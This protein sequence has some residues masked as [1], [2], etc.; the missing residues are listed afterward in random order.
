MQMLSTPPTLP[1]QTIPLGILT[2]IR[3]EDMTLFDKPPVP[4]PGTSS[5]TSACWKA[6]GSEPPEDGSMLAITGPAP[7]VLTYQEYILA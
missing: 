6:L 4:E 3:K 5:V 1:E 7:S 2:L